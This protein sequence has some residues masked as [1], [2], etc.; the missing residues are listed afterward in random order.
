MAIREQ[1]TDALGVLAFVL[2]VA[3]L[4]AFFGFDMGGWYHS[5]LVVAVLITL[6]KMA[7][8]KQS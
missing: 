1:K 6:Y 4:V 2:G 3:W 7:Q 8:N 5:L